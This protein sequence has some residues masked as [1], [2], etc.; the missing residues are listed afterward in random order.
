[1]AGAFFDCSDAVA[2][3]KKTEKK[4]GKKKKRKED[5]GNEE[6]GKSPSDSISHDAGMMIRSVH[7]ISQGD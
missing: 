1:M 6:D 5:K 3:P 2:I 7:L 4:K